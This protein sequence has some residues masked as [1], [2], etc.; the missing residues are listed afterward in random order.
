MKK[1]NIKLYDIL[2][3]V[4]ASVFAFM[5]AGKDLAFSQEA[6][7]NH[8]LNVE[9][10]KLVDTGV[11]A[12][13]D[14]EY[15]KTEH[16]GSL[17][18][19]QNYCNTTAKEIAGEG[20]VLLKNDNDALPLKKGSKVSL[21]G[22]GA[23]NTNYS[24]SGSSAAGDGITFPDFKNVMEEGG[25]FTVNPTT[26]AFYRTG[27]G[28]KYGRTEENLVKNVNETPWSEY[29]DD[30]KSSLSTY[31]DAAIV[32]FSRD[33]GEG[34]DVALTG[35]D[36]LDGS[37]LSLTQAEK[38]LLTNLTAMK[39][40]GKIKKIVVLLN[41]AVI[42]ETDFL[43]MDDIEVDACMWIG[44]VGTQGLYSVRDVLDG[45][46][47]PS[48]K[49]NDTFLRDNLSSPATSTWVNAPSGKISQR[50]SNYTDYKNKVNN[51]TQ[52]Y[53]INYNEGIY[54]GYRYYE[55][56]YEDVV[57]KKGN[58]GEYK[59]SD[60]VSYPFGYG[61]SYTTFS[62][63]NFSVEEKDDTFEVSITVKNTGTDY[64]GKEAV[65]IY[66]QKPYTDYDIEN[67]V[68]KSAVDLVGFTKTGV[69][70][71]GAEE[72]CKV[73]VD[74]E[75]M[76]S[77]DSNNAKTYIL[78]KGDYYLSV[79]NGAHDALNNVLSAKGYHVADGMDYDG[80]AT[81]VKKVHTQ[82]ELD[83]TTYSVSKE[84]GKAI[85]NQ[86]DF[87]DMNHYE[88][89]GN[90]SVTYLTRNN[91]TGTFP[92]NPVTFKIGNEKMADD[93]M[94]DKALPSSDGYEMPTYGASNGINL[95]SLRSTDEI[96]IP[97]DDPKWDKL[98][99]E[100]TYEEQS[101]LISSAGW[102]TSSMTSVNKPAT[103]DNDGPTGLINTK[104]GIVMPSLG[105]W[106]AS[107]NKELIQKVGDALAEDAIYAGYQSLYAPGINLHRTPFGGRLNEYFSED[108]NLTGF[109]AMYV[110]MGM[111]GKG[112]IPTVKH[113]AFN[114]EETNRNGVGVWMNEQEAR[115]LNL[116]PFEMVMR[117]SK[118]NAHAIMTSFNRAG[119]IWTSASPELMININ[120]DEF[121][122]DGYSLTDMASANGVSYMSMQDGVANGTDLWLASGGS[123]T[124]LDAYKNSAYF[125][126]RM[127]D[128]THRVLY[129][130]C[131]YSIAMNG[132]SSTT[133][134]VQVTPY[135]K[136]LIYVLIIVSAA[137]TVCF[138]VLK[139]LFLI[140]D[141]N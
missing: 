11:D 37:Y 95:I 87:M 93:L 128:A 19:L 97:Y 140:K 34:S 131:N 63:S 132:I 2:S 7:I 121:G 46:I 86:L 100:T 29:D 123:T 56:R 62:Y 54:V 90:N 106:A 82:N 125:A 124:A 126:N 89:K 79:G 98:L 36:G 92:T 13:V 22:Q 60:V 72:V 76:K 67:G 139:Y 108:S 119:C 8:N 88:N 14:T 107:F 10:T 35:S 18:D 138:L 51:A 55:T 31:N 69:L 64:S 16:N 58:A 83:T 129:V 103:K 112:V 30:T 32:V 75:E 27:K 5:L 71:P 109:A 57:M 105:I 113:Y 137:A 68:E 49:L 9:T 134:I 73:T 77:Y 4:S 21:M 120:R 81:L 70:A 136:I 52:Y 84:T 42:M 74:K 53:Y 78:D 24:T 101:L 15:F 3:I 116:K 38:D 41:M 117:P 85:T 91:W 65:E 1:H 44:V 102:N 12:N 130:I 99:D 23:V 40:E 45:D 17:Q 127:R 43:F 122:F 135:W 111:Q 96:T 39:K 47:V 26:D 133:K 61:L 6:V 66:M 115:E 48:G 59:Y 80:N 20:I 33:S 141:N 110:V 28:S 104:S 94:S 50:Y 25:A 114:N 118:G